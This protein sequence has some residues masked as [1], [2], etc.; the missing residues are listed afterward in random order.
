MALLGKN[1][2]SFSRRYEWTDRLIMRDERGLMM[3][4]GRDISTWVGVSRIHA[5]AHNVSS[6]EA[7]LGLLTDRER[8]RELTAGISDN[9]SYC[10][11]H[12]HG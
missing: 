7:D 1:F 10:L 6:F 5:H 12:H 3:E 8:E 9:I 11:Y 2:L 4:V